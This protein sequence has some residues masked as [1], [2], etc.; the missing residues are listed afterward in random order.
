LQSVFPILEAMVEGSREDR[1][2][3]SIAEIFQFFAE[4]LG[5]EPETVERE[6]RR[7][8]KAG[9]GKSQQ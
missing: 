3:L 6:F 7:W 1:V 8:Q 5:V 9:G 4:Q 2:R